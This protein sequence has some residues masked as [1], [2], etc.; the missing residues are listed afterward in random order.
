[1]ASRSTTTARLHSPLWIKQVSSSATEAARRAVL[2]I[3]E[4][5]SNGPS[6]V[7]AAGEGQGP[8]FMHHRA[9]AMGGSNHT[10][11]GK[12]DAARS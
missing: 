5:T 1:M 7:P 10:C 12:A 8:L 9:G 6:N 4:P 11:T 3:A 2:V